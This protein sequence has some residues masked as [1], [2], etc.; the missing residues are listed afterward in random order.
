MKNIQYLSYSSKTGGRVHYNLSPSEIE[1]KEK[2]GILI[3]KNP[4]LSRF[5][6]VPCCHLVIEKGKIRRANS[7]EVVAYEKE[8]Q[9]R[10]SE[11][12]SPGASRVKLDKAIEVNRLREEELH[13]QIKIHEKEKTELLLAIKKHSDECDDLKTRGR[14]YDKDLKW[15]L[16]IIESSINES[17]RINSEM[18]AIIKRWEEKTFSWVRVFVIFSIVLFYGIT[19]YKSRDVLVEFYGRVESWITRS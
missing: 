1:S 11:M 10:P 3:I 8:R 5:R 9:K 12:A 17:L 16:V 18:K 7:G 2:Q 6:E 14:E 4:D 15:K 13:Q 19:A